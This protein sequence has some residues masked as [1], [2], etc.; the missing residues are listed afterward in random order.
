M[1]SLTCL[2]KLT[3][4]VPPSCTQLLEGLKQPSLVIRRKGRP[5]NTKNAEEERRAKGFLEDLE[6]QAAAQRVLHEATDGVVA[7]RNPGG[8]G[9]PKSK[10]TC[11][12]CHQLGHRSNYCPNRGPGGRVV[13]PGLDDTGDVGGP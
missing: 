1:H 7:L 9:V 6:T 11:S 10:L 13:I 3:E 4:L 8:K 2:C 12:A 5:S